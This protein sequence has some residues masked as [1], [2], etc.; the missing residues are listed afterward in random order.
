MP[1]DAFI[2]AGAGNQVLVVIPSLDMI[3]V[4]FGALIDP[5][6]FWGGIEQYIFNPLMDCLVK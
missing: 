6:S 2:G 3:A 1:R 4:R 5:D